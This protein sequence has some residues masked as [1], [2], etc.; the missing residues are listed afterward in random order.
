[1]KYLIDTSKTNNKL[2]NELRKSLNPNLQ[3]V[4]RN[5]YN[6]FNKFLLSE[7]H[8]EIE[9]KITQKES[10]VFNKKRK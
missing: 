4:L 3:N 1:M 5:T 7:G 8:K 9:H 10:L 2:F 6:N